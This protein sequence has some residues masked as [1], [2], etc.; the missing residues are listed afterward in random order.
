MAVARSFASGNRRVYVLFNNLS[1]F[2]DAKRFLSYIENARFPPFAEQ[3]GY[4]RLRALL[5][6]AKFPASKS[7]L[8][9]K[10]GWRLVELE[11]G[12][13]VR[14]RETLKNL[15]SKTYG[16]PEDVLREVKL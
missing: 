16:K 12:K 6:K 11:D 13:Q 1:M 14:L 4:E 9:E 8:T 2:E 5:S 7:I 15:P 10:L 3:K